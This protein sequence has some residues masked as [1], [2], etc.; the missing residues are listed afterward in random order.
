KAKSITKIVSNSINSSWKIGFTGTLDGT[1]T[2]E[3]VLRGLFGPVTQVTTTK[4]LM[5]RKDVSNLTIRSIVLNYPDEERKEISKLNYHSYYEKLIRHEKRNRFILNLAKELPGNGLI[6][7]QFVD[8]HGKIL[9]NK[10]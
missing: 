10:M 4:K 8:K 9:Y 7:F 6:L 1:E 5:D 3:L 2:N